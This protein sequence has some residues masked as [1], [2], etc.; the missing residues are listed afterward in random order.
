MIERLTKRSNGSARYPSLAFAFPAALLAVV[1]SAGCAHRPSPAQ[2][3]SAGVGPFTDSRDQTLRV[4]VSAK[5]SL[6][7]ADLNALAAAYTPL[8]EKANAYAHFLVV[9][10]DSASF[11]VDQNRQCASDLT[12]AIIAFNK[13]FTGIASPQQVAATVSSGWVAPFAASVARDWGEYGASI[14]GMSSQAKAELTNQLRNKTLWPNYEDIATESLA[15][16]PH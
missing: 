3:L 5:H 1:L 13:A 9:S 12:A 8:E 15:T 7:A 6:G 2:N 11:S 14:G 4:I 16:P 10:V